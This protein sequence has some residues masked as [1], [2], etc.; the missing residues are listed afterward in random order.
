MPEVAL[1]V[2]SAGLEDVEGL[3]LYLP[4][5][6]PA[7]GQFGHGVRRDREICDE[8]VVVG[9]LS[10]VVEDFDGEPGDRYG[11]RGGAQRH[12]R[13]PAV[14]GCGVLASFADGLAMPLQF[15]A[16]EIFGDGLMGSRLAG[17]D[18][19]AAGVLDGGNDRLAGKQV[20]T[21]I[22]RPKMADR[23]AVPG[24][25]ALRGVA[26][27]VLRLRPVPRHDELRRQG[28]TCL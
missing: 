25:P 16:M 13:E 20:V 2:V 14:D 7:G 18:E 27:T 9:P 19:A 24:Q 8:A 6:P 15:G 23:G 5:R 4:A 12:R 26:F 22:N 10:L 28:R 1:E 21:K 11:I 17:K 3:V